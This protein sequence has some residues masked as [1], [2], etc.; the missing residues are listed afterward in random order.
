M[1]CAERLGPRKKGA[2]PC[3]VTSSTRS[4]VLAALVVGVAVAVPLSASAATKPAKPT[5]PMITTLSPTSAKPGMKV[6]IDGRHFV[7]VTE[8]KVDGLRAKYKFDSVDKI[9]AT[10][11]KRAK[12]GAGKVEVIT[13]SGTAFS[14][15]TLKIV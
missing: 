6:T 3:P 5:K 9:T 11:P 10:V 8:V 14:L 2:T 13:K 7:H 12:A 4:F 15:H 1:A